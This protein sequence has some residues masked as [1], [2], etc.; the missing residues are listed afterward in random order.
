MGAPARHLLYLFVFA[1]A[2]CKGHLYAYFHAEDPR[3]AFLLT[4]TNEACGW[5][6]IRRVYQ[7]KKVFCQEAGSPSQ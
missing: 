7:A 3:S 5:K 4:C 6:G 1:C 2:R